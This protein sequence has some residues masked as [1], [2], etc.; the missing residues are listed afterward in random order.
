MRILIADDNQRV[1]GAVAELLSSSP[2]CEV[3]GEAQDGLETIQ[4]AMQ[5]RLI[6]FFS[7]SHAWD[8]RTQVAHALRTQLP[9][10]RIVVMTSTIHHLLLASCEAAGA[11]SLGLRPVRI[12]STIER[13]TSAIK[14]DAGPDLRLPKP[15]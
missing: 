13:V 14:K 10:A 8:G 7:I 3:C 6:W 5:L 12:L 15:A 1:R 9:S 2:M 11:R 4:K